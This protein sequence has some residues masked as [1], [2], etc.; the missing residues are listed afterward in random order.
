M[1]MEFKGVR[2]P[3]RVGGRASQGALPR[4]YFSTR[5]AL[6]RRRAG[7][8][9]TRPSTKK[10]TDRQD[11]ACTASGRG[12]IGESRESAHSPALRPLGPWRRGRRGACLRSHPFNLLSF[13]H[14]LLLQGESHL[15]VP[16]G[17]GR[18][19]FFVVWGSV[20]RAPASDGSGPCEWRNGTLGRRSVT[21]GPRRTR[22]T[23]K[24]V[25]GPPAA[26][27]EA[28]SPHAAPHNKK[29]VSPQPRVRK[30]KRPAS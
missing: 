12:V 5:A 16:A 18:D 29:H 26:F 13:P 21:H 25:A 1:A 8:R 28:R 14:P 15:F 27:F 24:K 9:H 30:A 20:W 10:S 3:A 7:A 11:L 4:F 23:P 17:L 19:V 2:D 22:G 6:I